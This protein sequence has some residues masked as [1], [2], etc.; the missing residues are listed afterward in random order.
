MTQRVRAHSHPASH[1]LLQLEPIQ[2]TVTARR[3][4]ILSNS[5]V[6]WELPLRSQQAESLASVIDAN[7][8]KVLNEFPPIFDEILPCQCVPAEN[9]PVDG[10]QGIAGCIMNHAIEFLIPQTFRGIFER[11]SS[12]K[13]QAARSFLLED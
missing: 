4:H 12:Y 9:L 1:Q 11:C 8:G 6:L 10:E 3:L 5:P 2:Q 7:S 13:E